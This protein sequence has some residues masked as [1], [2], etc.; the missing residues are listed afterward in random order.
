VSSKRY[1]KRPIIIDAFQWNN[2]PVDSDAL[3]EWLRASDKVRIVDG[4]LSKLPELAIKTNLGEVLCKAGDYVIKSPSGELYPCDK[5][6]FEGLYEW[7]PE[8]AGMSFEQDAVSDT[9]VP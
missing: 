2:E 6:T 4:P 1:I 7:A 3:P 5:N 8:M 9:A